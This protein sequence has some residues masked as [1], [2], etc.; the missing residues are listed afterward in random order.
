[1][2][3]GADLWPVHL[4]GMLGIMEGNDRDPQRIKRFSKQTELCTTSPDFFF[5]PDCEHL[6]CSHEDS[7]AEAF[8]ETVCTGS[9]RQ[10]ETET[11]G[12]WRYY[13]NLSSLENPH[14]SLQMPQPHQMCSLL[15]EKGFRFCVF[16][17][18]EKGGRGS[19]FIHDYIHVRC[20]SHG[21]VP[22]MWNTQLLSGKARWKWWRRVACDVHGS[23]PAL[24][25]FAPGSMCVS[26]AD[27]RC[28]W[29]ASKCDL[30]TAS[31][32][33]CRYTLLPGPETSWDPQPSQEE[34]CDTEPNA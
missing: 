30:E 23:S 8:L 7:C 6:S 20:V 32:E 3:L 16:A 2:Y 25:F 21:Q 15:T 22:W 9:C 1:M 4:V 28:G 27:W 17:S 34:G 18:R 5:C 14:R 12:T 24:V 33:C 29:V 11:Q 19:R 13:L 10:G 26:T 31:M